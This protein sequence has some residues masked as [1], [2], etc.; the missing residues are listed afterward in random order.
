[1]NSAV[2]NLQVWACS[3]F[4]SPKGNP[5]YTSS[6]NSRFL[7]TDATAHTRFARP[8]RSVITCYSAHAQPCCV[9]NPTLARL[10][11]RSSEPPA[12]LQPQL[13]SPTLLLLLLV[14]DR[15]P[16]RRLFSLLVDSTLQ[17]APCLLPSRRG[18][19]CC[20]SRSLPAVPAKGGSSTS[21]S[22]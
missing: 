19:G 13:H 10:I 6:P 1:M 21:S 3:M 20:R 17:G 22:G 11:P 8:R 7:L 16:R 5:A 9:V 4:V 15:V 18:T 12:P 14:L 2:R